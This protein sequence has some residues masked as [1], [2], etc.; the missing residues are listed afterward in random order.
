MSL[1][2]LESQRE[3]ENNYDSEYLGEGETDRERERETDRDRQRERWDSAL[4]DGYFNLYLLTM[5]SFLSKYKKPESRV[6]RLFSFFLF[7]RK[8]LQ[9][10]CFSALRFSKVLVDC[11]TRRTCRPDSANRL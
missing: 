7:F 10:F 9:T 11:S 4:Y 5:A 3:R 2:T 1:Y 8:R 6:N